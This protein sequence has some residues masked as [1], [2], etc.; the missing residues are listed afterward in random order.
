MSEIKTNKLCDS[1]CCN[2]NNVLHNICLVN[3]FFGEEE[4][5]GT[6]KCPSYINKKDVWKLLINAENQFRD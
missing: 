2:R 6:D 5:H 3:I 4:M 1:C